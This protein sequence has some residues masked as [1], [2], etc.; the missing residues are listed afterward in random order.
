M[1]SN[2]TDLAESTALDLQLQQT[3]YSEDDMTDEDGST[4]HIPENLTQSNSEVHM[5][6]VV[7]E[8]TET[9]GVDYSVSEDGPSNH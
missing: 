4:Y 9:E 6:N 1:P 7:D 3:D 5:L 2:F 8:Q